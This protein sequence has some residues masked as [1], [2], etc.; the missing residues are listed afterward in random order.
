[1]EILTDNEVEE[2]K[3]AL[4]LQDTGTDE[5][6]LLDEKKKNNKNATEYYSELA[7]EAKSIYALLRADSDDGI[8]TRI[9]T[10]IEKIGS[11]DFPYR[12]K[13]D[14]GVRVTSILKS[15]TDRP[16]L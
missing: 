4:A 9:A 16:P 10:V 7:K 2:W 14:S 15:T 5:E 1:M 3:A 12:L 8:R 11:L 13:F 6:T